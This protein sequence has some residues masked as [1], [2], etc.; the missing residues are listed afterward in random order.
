MAL[1]DDSP[2]V[3]GNTIHRRRAVWALATLGNRCKEAG[4]LP[5]DQR[6]QMRQALEQEASAEKTRALWAR[7]G[8]YYLDPKPRGKA[9][10][11]GAQDIVFVDE[12]LAHC[13]KDPDRDLRARVAVALS[14]WDGELIEPTLL[15]L[16]RDTGF[17][18]LRWTKETD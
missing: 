1:R 4:K 13:A 17:G 7:H 11:S 10:A 16:A 5:A 14:F 12:V 15:R 8:L 9:R 6:E 2:D 3:K 18:Q